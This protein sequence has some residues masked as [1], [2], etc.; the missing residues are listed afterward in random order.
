MILSYKRSIDCTDDSS[1][2]EFYLKG[3]V[4][5]LFSSIYVQLKEKNSNVL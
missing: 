2:V 5:R 1:G 3:Y 4:Q